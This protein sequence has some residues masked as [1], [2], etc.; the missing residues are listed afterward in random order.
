MLD[1]LN[2][3]ADYLLATVERSNSTNEVT[4]VVGYIGD[5]EEEAARWTR[6]E[7]I[8]GE[9]PI[10]YQREVRSS[11][12]LLYYYIRCSLLGGCSSIQ[13]LFISCSEFLTMC[14][15]LGGAFRQEVL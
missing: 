13:A 10:E 3:G 1:T 9:R 4:G 12:Y 2:A 7:S 6:P 5:L 11:G 14:C 8:T 15:A